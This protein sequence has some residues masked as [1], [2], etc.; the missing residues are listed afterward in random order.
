MKE[1]IDY[2]MVRLFFIALL[3]GPCAFQDNLAFCL[4]SM[5]R[6]FISMMASIISICGSRITWVLFV[7]PHF[8]SLPTIEALPWLYVVY[9]ISWILASIA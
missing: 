6:S 7:F 8:S 4:K 1:I 5:D 3:Y 2:G 9:L